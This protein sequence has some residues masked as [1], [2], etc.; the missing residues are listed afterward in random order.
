[1]THAFVDKQSDEQLQ[2]VVRY[3][4]GAGQKNAFY[5]WQILFHQANHAMQHRSEVALLMTS[6]GH[7]TG[8][9]DFGFY[10]STVAGGPE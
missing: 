7:S 8:E 10:V 3:T 9:L 6:M 1:M 5:M 2:D 4:N